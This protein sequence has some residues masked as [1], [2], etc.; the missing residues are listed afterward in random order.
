MQVLE[1]GTGERASRFNRGSIIRGAKRGGSEAYENSS[2][3]YMGDRC[4][5]VS[6]I[7]QFPIS[8]S[9][10]EDEQVSRERERE[11]ESH[12]VYESLGESF[13]TPRFRKLDER[14][15]GRF[16]GITFNQ[17]VTYA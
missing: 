3:S 16:R 12:S 15:D 8:S 11:K 9:V 2:T 5:M 7:A 17:E 4:K 10:R 13:S 1:G 6:I 14:K